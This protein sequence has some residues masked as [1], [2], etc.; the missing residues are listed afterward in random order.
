MLNLKF[1]L[2]AF[3]LAIAY[4]VLSFFS[5]MLSKKLEEHNS[6]THTMNNNQINSHENP[7]ID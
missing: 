7:F 5:K 6:H 2:L 3:S 1:S 4:S